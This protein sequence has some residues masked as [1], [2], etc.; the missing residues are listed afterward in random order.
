MN[1]SE[2]KFLERIRIAL[3]NAESHAEIKAALTEYGIDEAKFAQGWELYNLGK[4]SWELNKQEESETRLVSNS[5]HAAY[6][7][8]EMKFKRHRDLSL[9]LCKKDP[10]TLIQLGVKGRFPTKYNEF[11]DKVK[12][13]YTIASTETVVQ[14]KLAFIKLS[15]EIAATCLGELEEVLALR[16]NFDKEMGESQVATVSKNAAL[17]NLSEWMDEFDTIAKIALYD[18]PQHLEVLGVLVK[19]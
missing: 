6:G 17:H 9:I 10:D 13:F 18:T 15:P 19:S 7:K 8:L 12:L 11:F 4:Y 1:Q 16:A 3:T 5:Y 2:S 14:D